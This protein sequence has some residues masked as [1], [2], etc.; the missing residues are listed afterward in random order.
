M[1]KIINTGIESL[2]DSTESEPY[3]GWYIYTRILVLF[4]HH[5][6][7]QKSGP[8]NRRSFLPISCATELMYELGLISSIFCLH[9]YVLNKEMVKPEALSCNSRVG[10]GGGGSGLLRRMYSLP[11][12]CINK[13]VSSD[14]LCADT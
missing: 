4:V 12:K 6:Q 11:R 7:S 3:T 5:I 1:H 10:M 8:I 13:L 9:P 14:F 2:I